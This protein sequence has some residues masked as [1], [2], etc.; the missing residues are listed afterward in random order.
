MSASQELY[1]VN[2][3][4]NTGTGL[5]HNV[6]LVTADP[7]AAIKTARS[8]QDLGYEFYLYGAVHVQR[9]ELDLS[10][11]K[12][13]FLRLGGTPPPRC[14]VYARTRRQVATAEG[15]PR[16]YRWEDEWMDTDLWKQYDASTKSEDVRSV[17]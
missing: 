15:Q 10:Y 2:V 6:V 14:V 12:R 17:V 1:V 4:H 3:M 13:C 9:V 8:V 11:N 5:F 16:R 7:M